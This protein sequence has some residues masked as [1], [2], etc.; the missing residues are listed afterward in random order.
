[1]TEG[2]KNLVANL[3]NTAALL[4]EVMDKHWIGFYLVDLSTNSLVLGPFQGPLACTRIP[5]GKGVCGSAWGQKQILNVPNVHE[6]EGHIACSSATNSEIVAPII[7]NGS[8][9]A[10]LDI[11]SVLEHDFDESDV[12]GLSDIVDYL[13]ELF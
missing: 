13:S 1:M 12:Q 3:S 2:E 4:M 8:V 11:D 9:I 5:F 6:F 10:V 7:K